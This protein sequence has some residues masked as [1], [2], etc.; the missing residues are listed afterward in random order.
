LKDEI[1]KKSMKKG[2]KRALNQLGLTYQTH[3]LGYETEKPYR[4]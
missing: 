2:K 4:K 3:D 1:E